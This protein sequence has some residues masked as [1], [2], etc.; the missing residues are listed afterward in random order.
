MK[1][2]QRLKRPPIIEMDTAEYV[3]TIPDSHRGPGNYAT[4]LDRQ[5]IGIR[6][7]A[8]LLGNMYLGKGHI[9]GREA[10]TGV[11]EAME[12]SRQYKT[13]EA[14]PSRSCTT[15]TSA[16]NNGRLQSPRHARQLCER[17]VYVEE[18]LMTRWDHLCKWFES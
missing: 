18:A 13:S 4:L 11:I 14:L 2:V 17:N 5:L 6:A 10:T 9:N 1:Y 7:D 15:V 8:R 16:I 3:F 12:S